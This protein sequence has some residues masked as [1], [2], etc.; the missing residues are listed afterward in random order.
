MTAQ[1]VQ[2]KSRRTLSREGMAEVRE[3]VARELGERLRHEFTLAGIP[4]IRHQIR[5]VAKA[6]GVSRRHAGRWVRG[7]RS[8]GYEWEGYGR[9][10]ADRLGLYWVYV[11]A[12]GPRRVA[13]RV[14]PLRPV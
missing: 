6:T 8:F 7:E 11:V 5:E 13:P 3:R 10:I 2:F 9:A 4:D 1:I 12:G 14:V